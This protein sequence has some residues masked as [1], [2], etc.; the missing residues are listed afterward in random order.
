MKKLGA[1]F[2]VFC[3][4]LCSPGY[5]FAEEEVV[6]I[7]ETEIGET[8]PETPANNITVENTIENTEA[9]NIEAEPE[10]DD[11]FLNPDSVMDTS[12]T[13]TTEEQIPTEEYSEFESP[14]GLDSVV[15]LQENDI[16]ALPAEP[17]LSTVSEESVVEFTTTISPTVVDVTI[18]LNVE[19]YINPNE[20]DGFLYG[21]IEVQNH[22]KAPIVVSVKNFQTDTIPFANC[23]APYELPGTMDWDNMSVTETQRY[24]S[25]GMKPICFNNVTWAEEYVRDY[26]YAKK[27][28]SQIRLGAIAGNQT[29]YIGLRSFYGKAF[30]NE[31]RF[32]F[33]ATF[34][35][36]LK[37]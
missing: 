19:I 25:I 31:K 20:E 22:T 6:G 21:A 17:V 2:L 27:G 1:L 10:T 3:I 11:S 37:Q 33:S 12:A 34:V 14:E 23:I 29:A 4:C 15:T 30:T 24:F 9:A 5:A 16:T 32:Q 26:V 13:E 7:V 8:L 28:F 35:V 36:E 18:P